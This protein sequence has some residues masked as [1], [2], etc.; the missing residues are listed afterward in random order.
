MIHKLHQVHFSRKILLDILNKWNTSYYKMSDMKQFVKSEEQNSYE[1][2]R[3][4]LVYTIIEKTLSS[5][6]IYYDVASEMKKK[7]NCNVY[8]CYKHPEYFSAILHTKYND[9]Y[10]III[11][12][13]DRQLEM[14]SYEKSIA[15]FLQKI[16]S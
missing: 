3:E 11:E 7:F 9:M 4:M 16:N 5:A 12:S 2:L 8:E 10:D 1:K 13:I 6:G 14:F 15:T